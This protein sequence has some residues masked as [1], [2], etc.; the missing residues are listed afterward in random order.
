MQEKCKWDIHIKKLEYKHTVGVNWYAI[1]DF[2][3]LS[4]D[5][6]FG[7]ATTHW[8]PCGSSSGSLH[9]STSTAI[10]PPPVPPRTT[11]VMFSVS[12]K[13]MGG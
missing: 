10:G 9:H 8:Y 7:D 2:R 4:F 3:P 1:N 6:F 12:G 5:S 11:I 13:W